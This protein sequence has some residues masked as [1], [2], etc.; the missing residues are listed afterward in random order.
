MLARARPAGLH[1]R[2]LLCL[3]L[4]GRLAGRVKR[5]GEWTWELYDPPERARGG[6]REKGKNGSTKGSKRASKKASDDS[7]ASG[8]VA[9]YCTSDPLS[10]NNCVRGYVNVAEMTTAHA[11]EA[12]RGTTKERSAHAMGGGDDPVTRRMQVR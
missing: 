8:D 9:E 2:L 3:A 7:A 1:E 12:G 6:G 5:D 10:V 11:D 4:D